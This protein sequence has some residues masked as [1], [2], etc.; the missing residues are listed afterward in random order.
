MIVAALIL[1]ALFLLTWWLSVRLDNYS[2]VDVTWSLAFAPVASWYAFSGTGW[3]LRK[4]SV[5]LLVS[6]W[7][8]RLGI[9]L[10]H[11]VAS[12]HPK[13]DVRYAVLREKW[14][15]QPQRAF[16][17]FFLAQAVLVWLLMV[18][19]HLICQQHTDSFHILEVIGLCL[20]FVALLGE[21]I[22]D[23]QLEGFKKSGSG[24]VCQQGLWRYSRHPNYFFQ[25]LLWWG[26]F[27][28][29]LPAS[30]GWVAIIAPLSMLHFLLNVTG[31]P[32]T[33]KLSVERRGEAYREYQRTT[34]A[35][36]PWFRKS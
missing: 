10:W 26:L 6:A 20:W 36:I 29:A 15:S 30:W 17:F 5:A 23:A 7:S 35:F 12:H 8:L 16:L 33:E 24:G 25:S 9:Y 19:V 27:L 22:A 34:S 14:Q 31:I 1:L 11:R 28:M 32:L 21:G 2:F 4:V 13:E 3:W 18:P